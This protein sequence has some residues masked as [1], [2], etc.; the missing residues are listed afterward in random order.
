MTQSTPQNEPL[1]E[2][3][4]DPVAL[5]AKIAQ[6]V[7]DAQKHAAAIAAMNERLQRVE[8]VATSSGGDVKIRVNEKCMITDLEL[9]EH[10]IRLGRKSLSKLILETMKTAQRSVARQALEISEGVLGEEALAQV[11]GD[12]EAQLG[13]IDEDTTGESDKP[14]GNETDQRSPTTP[15]APWNR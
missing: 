10:T 9:S 15:G 14:A 7:E 6:Q 2:A 12:Y 11:R 5:K 13:Y 4:P 8:G 1:A 3:L